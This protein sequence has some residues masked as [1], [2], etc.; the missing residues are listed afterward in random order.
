M[1]SAARTSPTSRDSDWARITKRF[2][3]AAGATYI[4]VEDVILGPGTPRPRRI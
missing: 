1:H 3:S 4:A 2:P